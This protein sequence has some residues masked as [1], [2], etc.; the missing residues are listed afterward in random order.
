MMFS[1]QRFWHQAYCR[2]HGVPARMKLLGC[3]NSKDK[4]PIRTVWK[5]FYVTHNVK[6]FGAKLVA[7]SC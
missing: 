5:C 7:G 6:T 4:Q 1:E 3:G 2:K